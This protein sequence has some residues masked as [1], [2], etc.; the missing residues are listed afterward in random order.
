MCVIFFRNE[1]QTAKGRLET[2]GAF[3]LG[4]HVF[5]FLSMYVYSFHSPVST[6]LKQKK[7][8]LL[9]DRNPGFTYT[10]PLTLSLC[11]MNQSVVPASLYSSILDMCVMLYTAFTVLHFLPAYTYIAFYSTFTVNIK[12]IEGRLIIARKAFQF[13]TILCFYQYN[14]NLV[15]SLASCRNPGLEAGMS[16]VTNTLMTVAGK[17]GRPS[18]ILDAK[19]PFY[20][21][22]LNH[23]LHLFDLELCQG[24]YL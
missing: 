4:L 15:S 10:L 2:R 1:T 21:F 3:T 20:S 9:Q 6:D 12:I 18:C 23:S 7:K 11:G 5:V 14:E 22:E 17:L 24:L 16:S 13:Y 8:E 19:T